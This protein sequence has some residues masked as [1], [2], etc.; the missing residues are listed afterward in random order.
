MSTYSQQLQDIFNEYEKAGMPMPATSK[1][2]AAGQLKM[3]CGP[4]DRQM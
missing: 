2:V 1:D 3:D 4:P